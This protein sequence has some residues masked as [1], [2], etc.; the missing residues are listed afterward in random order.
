MDILTLDSNGESKPAVTRHLR[1]RKALLACGIVSSLLYIVATI[2]GAVQWQGY[3][4]VDQSV[5][6]LIGINAPSAPIVVPLFFIYSVLIYAF[7]LGVWLSAGQKR[8]LRVAAVLMIAKEVLGLYGLLFARVHLRGVQPT[9]SDSIHLIITGVGVLLSMF[10]AMGFAATVFGKRFR[11]YSIATLLIFLVFGALGGMAGS[12]IA[13]NLPTPWLGV[14]E[15]INIFGYMVWI[16]VLAIML[17][18]GSSKSL[19]LAVRQMTVPAEA[20]VK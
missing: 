10:P 3:S 18:R 1:M 8:A 17:L 19:R 9:Q 7:G 20:A 6:E 15:R 12:G 5:S 11:L 4:T 14:Y 13:T 16:V 2:L